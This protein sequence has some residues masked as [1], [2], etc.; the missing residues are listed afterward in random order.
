MNEDGRELVEQVHREAIERWRE[1]EEKGRK[2]VEAAFREALERERAEKQ[3]QRAAVEQVHREAIE[4]GRV[5]PLLPD[6]PPTIPYTELPD[7]KVDSPIAS[8]WNLYR[9]EVGRLLAEGHENRWV[10][11]K[12]EEII[13]IWETEH[14]ARAVALERYL[15]QPCLIQQIRSREP[16]VRM[17]ARFGGCQR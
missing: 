12:G 5:Q 11:I 13:G 8:E 4:Q 3:R 14:E 6:E 2:L 9:R 1:E 10:L 7:G 16:I 15:M 17:S